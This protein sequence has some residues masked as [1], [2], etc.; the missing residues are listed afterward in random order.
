MANGAVIVKD[1]LSGN[2]FGPQHRPE[3]WS[4]LAEYR[5]CGCDDSDNRQGAYPKIFH[6]EH[7]PKVSLGRTSK[8][9][10][11]H[12]IGSKNLKAGIHG[13]PSKLGFSRVECNAV[14]IITEIA[15]T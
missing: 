4:A 11:A 1:L 14:T 3:L 8:I 15:K 5:G 9:L 13:D 12:I 6:R 10:P 2:L 7:R